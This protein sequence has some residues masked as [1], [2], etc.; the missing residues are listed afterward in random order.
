MIVTALWKE[1]RVEAMP[2]TSTEGVEKFGSLGTEERVLGRMRI[3]LERGFVEVPGCDSA[4]LV[5]F[6]SAQKAIEKI[7]QN[8]RFN[9]NTYSST[10]SFEKGILSICLELLVKGLINQMSVT[11]AAMVIKPTRLPPVPG[12][13]LRY[14]GSR[15]SS[16]S[17]GYL[18]GYDAS[19]SR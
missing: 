7:S 9:Q 17:D 5:A 14:I 19:A 4:L 3:W 12:L 8:L 10:T 16:K 15:G 1:R 6:K 18:G 2:A 11:R 13:D